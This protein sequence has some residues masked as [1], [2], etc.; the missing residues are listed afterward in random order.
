MKDKEEMV[1]N[2]TLNILKHHFLYY[3][4]VGKTF[5]GKMHASKSTRCHAHICLKVSSCCLL[6]SRPHSSTPSE[7]SR[8]IPST[9]LLIS[10]TDVLD[11]SLKTDQFSSQKTLSEK[12]CCKEDKTVK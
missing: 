5:R 1:R 11:Q 3:V 6:V 9:L 8:S 2:A 7:R 4:A 12:I 10:Q